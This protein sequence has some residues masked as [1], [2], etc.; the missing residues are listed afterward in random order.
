MLEENKL[1]VFKPNTSSR[2]SKRNPKYFKG[3]YW[4]KEAVKLFYSKYRDWIIYYIK[5]PYGYPFDYIFFTKD[6]TY[7]I[8]LLEVKYRHDT[9]VITISASKLRKL[10]EYL[11]KWEKIKFRYFIIAMYQ[12]KH[13]YIIKDC[14]NEI[15]NKK[16]RI[17]VPINILQ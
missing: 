9:N 8:W 15:N 4:E 5:S 16:I 3:Y 7:P 14:I 1:V 11:S 17:E 13:N 12:S 2:S 6:S 10:R